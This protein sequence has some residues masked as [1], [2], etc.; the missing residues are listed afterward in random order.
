MKI[1]VSACL[2]G[3]RVRYDGKEKGSP[4][5][6][7]LLAG[8]QVWLLCPEVTGGLPV[9]RH[10]S[11]RQGGRVVNRAGEDVTEAYLDGSR[12]CL[13]VL[14]K[15]GIRAAVLKAKSPA[16]GIH[17][18]YDG[19]FAGR[20]KEGMGTFAE[21]CAAEGIRLFDETETEALRRFLEEEDAE[22]L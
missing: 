22:I 11:E 6:M 14:K 20:L 17:A 18:V 3:N 15:N 9:P 1:G 10:P 19:S 16:C 2:L 21:M 5:I 8:H 7:N 13:S 4:E 12:V